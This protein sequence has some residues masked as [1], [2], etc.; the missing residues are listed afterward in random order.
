MNRLDSGKFMQRDVEFP[1]EFLG[2]KINVIKAYGDKFF[3]GAD[4][5]FYYK[6][7][8]G[9]F[10]HFS[11]DAVSRI[12][13]K[14]ENEIYFSS[15]KALYLMSE[16]KIKEFQT[17]NDT[18]TGI[19]GEDEIYLLTE[20]DLYHLEEGKFVRFLGNDMPSYGLSVANGKIRSFSGRRLT[21]FAGK[22]PHWMCI[23]PEHTEMPYF[24][25]NTVK[26]DPSTGFVWLGTDEGLCLYDDGACWYMSDKIDVL[27]KDEIFD[28]A[29]GEKGE[30]ALASA[31]GVIIIKNGSRKYLPATRYVPVS[32]VN[33]IEMCNGIIYAGTDEGLSVISEKEMTLEEKAEY[34]FD[35][36]EKYF[37][38]KDGYTAEKEKVV[39]RDLSTGRTKIT[40]NDGLWTQIYVAALAYKY[41]V[42]GD[43][44][45]LEAARRSM[46]AM[47]KLTQI[48]GIPGFTARAV[49]YPGEAGYGTYIDSTVEGSEW[50]KAPDGVTEW[51]GETSSDEMTGHFFGFSVYY[52]LCAND[53]E[54]ELIKNVL[55]GI[56][57]HILA[58]NYHLIDKDGLPTTW[59]CW[60]PAELNRNNMWQWEKC[61]NSLEFLSFLNVAYHISG[62]EKYRKE[63]IHLAFEEKYLINAAHHKRDDGRVTHIDDNLAFL[64]TI[65]MLR[66]E[67]DERIKS[68]IYM[69]M[70]NHFDY[71]R[72]EGFAFWNLIYGAFTGDVCDIDTA[73]D[74]LKNMPLNLTDVHMYNSCRKDLVYDT[75]QEMWGGEKQLKNPL[76]IDERSY[77]VFSSNPYDVDGGRDDRAVSPANYL[78]PYW[79]GRYYNML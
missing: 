19:D 1:A 71:E 75:E 8:D 69:G 68:Y 4:D 7:E 35:L 40:D 45:A 24:N 44:K 39:N 12:Y 53:E 76:S 37:I 2:L 66:L 36:C 59:A 11:C 72:S 77:I 47:V 52:D 27:P 61:V 18:V 10:G 3:I 21:V 13:V 9:K 63:F 50:H 56:V 64:S 14:D 38:R 48:T 49:R 15:G 41:A 78:L 17:F 60:D 25:I 46:N 67:K 43:K 42:T 6:K 54:K 65:N 20:N 28:I 74:Y 32:K 79:F 5:G 55:C 16:G 29:F 62:D 23:Y 26:I 73:V 70:K 31:A 34:Y 30:M 51:L 57:D 33:C 58:N 22:R